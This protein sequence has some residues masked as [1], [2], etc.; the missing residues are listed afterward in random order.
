M[1]RH[2]TTP[3]SDEWGLQNSSSIQ[4]AVE[5]IVMGDQCDRTHYR[6]QDHELYGSPFVC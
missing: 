6:W 4:P 2:N 3:G 1:A 5:F